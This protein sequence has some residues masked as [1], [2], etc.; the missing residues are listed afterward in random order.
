ME[1]DEP[2]TLFLRL[3]GSAERQEQERQCTAG[4]HAPV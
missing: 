2:L 3:G 4:A 1:S